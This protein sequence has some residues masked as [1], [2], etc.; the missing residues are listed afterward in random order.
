MRVLLML[1]L[2]LAACAKGPWCTSA[3]CADAPCTPGCLFQ[4]ADGGSCPSALPESTSGPSGCAGYC[5]VDPSLGQAAGGGIGYCWHYDP[6]LPGACQSPHCG[7]N[8]ACEVHS[9][10]FDLT[11]QAVVCASGDA[12]FD[13]QF[14]AD[15][16]P[17]C[18]DLVSPG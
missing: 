9:Y 4:R 2:L 5:T 1:S 15:E 18:L 16:A 11:D 12:C 7:W 13:G 14:P 3:A 6:N 8:T 17:I 10:P